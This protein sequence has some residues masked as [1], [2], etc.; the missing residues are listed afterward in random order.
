MQFVRT[1]RVIVRAETKLRWVGHRWLAGVS[2]FEESREKVQDGGNDMDRQQMAMVQKAMVAPDDFV[3]RMV[4][5]DRAGTITERM[6]SPIRFLDARSMLALCLCREFPRR[7]ELERC[8]SIEVVD[9]NDVLMPVE[10]KQ[11]EAATSTA[12]ECGAVAVA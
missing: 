1:N 5:K 6:V 4:Y 9:A 12:A 10:I 2:G 11:L 7:F 8:S 3:L